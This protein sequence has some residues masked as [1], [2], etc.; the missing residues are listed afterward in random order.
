MTSPS[1]TA[2]NMTFGQPSDLPTTQI[3]MTLS[4]RNLWNRDII[5]KSDPFCMVLMKNSWIDRYFE[6]GRTETVKDSLSPEWVKKFVISYSFETVQKMRFEIWDVDPE[7]K[8]FLGHF[9][10]TLADIVA[11]S[12]RQ[13][14]GKLTGNE[15]RNYGELIVVVEE[16]SSCK[17]IVEMQF[18]ATNLSK[19]SWLSQ[20]DPFLVFSR[21]NEDGTHSVVMKS[22]KAFSTQ[23]PLWKPMTL[24]VRTLCNGD[25]D[26]SIK[27]DCYDYRSN[28]NHKLIGSCHT[29]LRTLSQGPKEN[30]YLLV[31]PIKQK[32]KSGY[33]NSG[34]L[35][36]NSITI[37]EEITFLDFIRTGTQMHFAVAIDFTA[38]NGPPH[39]PQ[40]LHFLSPFGNRPNPYEIAL[41][42]IGDII[43]HYDSTG[44]YPA[45]GI[46]YRIIKI[47]VSLI[48]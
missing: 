32:V 6:V 42:S 12:G 14:V 10:T 15:S 11:Y 46:Y 23:N 34:H 27:I 44:M 20:N 43:Q 35:E 1:P 19:K 33:T 29:S 47:I 41:R 18:R 16:V 48:I 21:S 26:R 31:N 30:K 28:G 25:Y 8:E 22:E 9:E 38:T 3:E 17:Q 4:A 24:R 39:D 7:G 5:S 2:P 45:F 37:T 13:F 40:S 36:L